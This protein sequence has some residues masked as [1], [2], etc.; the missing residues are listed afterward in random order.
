MAEKKFLRSFA[1]YTLIEHKY[2]YNSNM[3]SE[4]YIHH[5]GNKIE[6]R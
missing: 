1:V 4:V 3:R 6:R 5:R 2:M